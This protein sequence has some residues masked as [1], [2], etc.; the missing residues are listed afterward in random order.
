MEP[1][2]MYIINI[3]IKYLRKSNTFKRADVLSMDFEN[4]ILEIVG[5]EILEIE[6]VMKLGSINP[7]LMFKRAETVWV[8]YTDGIFK[9]VSD[10]IVAPKAKILLEYSQRNVRSVRNICISFEHDM[11][12]VIDDYIDKVIDKTI[13]TD[14]GLYVYF[15]INN[16][17]PVALTVKDTGYCSSRDTYSP[18]IVVSKLAEYIQKNS[19]AIKTANETVAKLEAENKRLKEELANSKEKS[20][21]FLSWLFS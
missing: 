17:S 12:K 8:Q 3:L 13:A 7:A 9:Y 15:D 10:N 6:K 21:G 11:V 14:E 4:L 5:N 20:K 18:N 19:L 1:E 16:Q 2:V